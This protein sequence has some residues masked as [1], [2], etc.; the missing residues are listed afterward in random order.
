MGGAIDPLVRG[1]IREPFAD[2]NAMNDFIEEAK[3][4]M[5]NPNYHLYGDMYGSFIP[6]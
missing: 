4:G 1:F 5:A 2:E 3:A 6:C